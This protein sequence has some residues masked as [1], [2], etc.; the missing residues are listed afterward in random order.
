LPFWPKERGASWFQGEEGVE[1]HNLRE[2]ALIVIAIGVKI[3]GGK[4]IQKSSLLESE[5]TI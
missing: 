5:M 3:V 4:N 1:E 2:E